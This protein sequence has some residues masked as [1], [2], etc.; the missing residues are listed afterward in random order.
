MKIK[1]KLKI[2]ILYYLVIAMA[3]LRKV[4]FMNFSRCCIL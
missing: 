2:Q 3:K 1:I 4:L